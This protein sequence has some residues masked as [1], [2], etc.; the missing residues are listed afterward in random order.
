METY[1]HVHAHTYVHALLRHIYCSGKPKVTSQRGA[2]RS[3]MP[4][5]EN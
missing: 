5:Q 2:M 4:S 3:G 1:V